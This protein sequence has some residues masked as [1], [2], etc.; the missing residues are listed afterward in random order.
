MAAI[1]QNGNFVVF[2]S[3]QKLALYDISEK[4]LEVIDTVAVE[5]EN[6]IQVEE[7]KG[8]T[9]TEGTYAIQTM[10]FSKSGDWFATCND[11][12]QLML[13]RTNGALNWSKVST[14]AM[15]RRVNK[16][17]F[18][19]SNNAILVADKAGDVYSYPVDRPTECGKLLMG[20]LS[21]LLDIAITPN[22]E[23]IITCDRDEKIRVSHYPN[24]YNI[25]AYCLGHS[26]F[27]SQIVLTGER[28]TLVSGSGDGTLRL[29]D[30]SKGKQL[31]ITDCLKILEPGTSTDVE[32]RSANNLAVHSCRFHKESSTL[33]VSF[34]WLKEGLKEIL[35]YHLKCDHQSSE[36]QY[37][38]TLSVSESPWDISFDGEGNLWVLQQK[39]D[40]PV[41]VFT[42]EM[43][44]EYV[45]LPEDHKLYTEHVVSL[46][47]HWNFFKASLNADNIYA[48]LYKSRID[49]MKDYFKRKDQKLNKQ[50]L[51]QPEAIGAPPAKVAKQS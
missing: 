47:K 37:K 46:N 43:S 41:M 34:K 32:D 20:H 42:R 11:R 30:Y 18:T 26:E 33:A 7:P 16:V 24:A 35:L 49:N 25:H 4:K 27:V 22:D 17:T 28:D 51:P 10:S 45:K 19:H 31:A 15:Q 3:G 12:K 21:M 44:N 29:W 5:P 50:K 14:R 6:E 9:P 36:F 39:E 8:C 23:L 2:S 1:A 48:F 13:W 40:E 38:Q